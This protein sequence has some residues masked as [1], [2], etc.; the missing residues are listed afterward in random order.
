MFEMLE[1]FFDP[2]TFLKNTFKKFE[3]KFFILFVPKI[4]QSQVGLAWLRGGRRGK[5]YA[6]KYSYF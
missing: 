2:I 3:C 5:F 1:H 6:E 4:A